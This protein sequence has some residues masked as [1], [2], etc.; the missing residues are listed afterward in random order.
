MLSSTTLVYIRELSQPFDE[1]SHRWAHVFLHPSCSEGHKHSR[2]AHGNGNTVLYHT[3][4]S[5]LVGDSK[6]AEEVLGIVPSGERLVRNGLVQ[7]ITEGF[8]AT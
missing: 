7:E 8:P 3:H 6:T 5:P 1:H 2:A 4:A